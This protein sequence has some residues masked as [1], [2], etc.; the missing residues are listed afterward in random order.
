MPTPTNSPHRSITLVDPI[1]DADGI[2]TSIATV[3]APASYSGGALNGA[4]GSAA[5]T[6]GRT[7]SVTSAANVGSYVA[8]SAVTFTGTDAHGLAQT[9]TLL[10][11]SANGGETI[12]GNKAFK[13]VT[14]IDVAAQV[15]VNGAFT[16]GYQDVVCPGCF[17]FRIGVDGDAK[18]GFADGS[19]DTLPVLFA[20]ETVALTIAKLYGSAA[21]TATKITLY[22]AP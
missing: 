5:R 19:S 16:F 3:A 7:V 13:T 6:P 12:V 10:L 1:A 18:V 14:Q 2:K 17:G 20:G 21:T 9:E 22:F 11:T 4:I 8:G 15:N